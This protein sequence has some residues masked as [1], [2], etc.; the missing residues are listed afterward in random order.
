MLEIVTC[1]S[2]GDKM[3]CI[4]ET[5]LIVLNLIAQNGNFSKIKIFV[6]LKS[7]FNG[8]NNFKNF[9][10]FVIDCNNKLV[11]AFLFCRLLL[12]IYNYGYKFFIF[13]S[14]NAAVFLLL[15]LLLGQ[16][17][18]YECESQFKIFLLQYQTM[19]QWRNNLKIFFSS[20]SSLSVEQF[21][22][23][24]RDIPLSRLFC[25]LVMQSATRWKYSMC[26]DAVL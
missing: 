25:Y 18:E 22:A 13:T 15:T 10:V 6:V 17:R 2:K 20:L 5:T 11:A 21:A 7:N 23:V 8:K 16:S 3:S 9:K 14:V 12:V 1:N 19:T 24:S 4:C 26:R